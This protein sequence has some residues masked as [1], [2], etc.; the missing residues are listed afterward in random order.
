MVEDLFS[1]MVVGWSMAATMA[2]RLVVDALEMGIARR[3]P[4]AGLLV[5]SDRGS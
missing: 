1:R 5:H 3:R 4:D 2:S